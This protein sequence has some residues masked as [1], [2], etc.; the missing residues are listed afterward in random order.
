MV[1][2]SFADDPDLTGGPVIE[3]SHEPDLLCQQNGLFW[4][5]AT[6]SG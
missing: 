2:T 6:K 5:K 1:W 3:I 4:P